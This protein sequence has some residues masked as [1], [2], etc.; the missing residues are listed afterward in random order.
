MFTGGERMIG[1]RV[2][3]ACAMSHGRGSG[4]WHRVGM[5]DKVGSDNTCLTS[6]LDTAAGDHFLV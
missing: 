2:G 6:S 3:L 4:A 5:P 1:S